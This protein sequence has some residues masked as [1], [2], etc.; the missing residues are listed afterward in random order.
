[1]WLLDIL[2]A[3]EKI[4]K[5]AHTGEMAFF[6]EEL[7]QV[8]IIYY[9]QIIGEA[10]NHLSAELTMKH[11]KIPWA[12]IVAMRNVMVHHYF[13]IDLKEVWDTV[14]VDLPD[15]KTK[16]QELLKGLPSDR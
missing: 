6:K 9:L 12:K 2:E 14:C 5:Y 13:G 11:D 3:I 16:L 4:E 1:M 8:W 15:L 10:A 7:I